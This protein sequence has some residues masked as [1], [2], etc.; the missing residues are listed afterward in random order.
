MRR[1]DVLYKYGIFVDH[2]SS[3]QISACGSCIFI[4]IWINKGKPTSGCTSLSEEQIVK[5]L[6][7]LDIKKNPLLIQL[8]EKEFEKIKTALIF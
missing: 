5:L 8:P 2:N 7:W 4:H 6:H 1:D 3:P